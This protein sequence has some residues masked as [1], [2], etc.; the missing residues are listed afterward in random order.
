M[1]WGGA[2]RKKMQAAMRRR[3]PRKP[4]FRPGS[5]RRL[6]STKFSRRSYAPGLTPESKYADAAYGIAYQNSNV[7]AAPIGADALILDA[8]GPATVQADQN[9]GSPAPA[10]GIISGPS[11]NQRIGRK[12]FLK[13]LSARMHIYWV[14]SVAPVTAV[15]C[16]PTCRVRVMLFYDRQPNLGVPANPNMVMNINPGL[17]VETFQEDSNRDRFVRLLDQTHQLSIN[18]PT[19]PTFNDASQVTLNK[20]IKINGSQ[21]YNDLGTGTAASIQSGSLF[22]LFMWD[23]PGTGVVASS[24][25]IID[26]C[27]R[28]RYSDL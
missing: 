25:P 6:R 2:S 18:D 26:L 22:W 12:I 8:N 27:T 14:Q 19:V 13:Y 3:R 4:S 1:A 17:S 28:L 11:F 21:I 23:L 24:P 10:A 5:G 7:I 16:R 9:T 20:V 15:T